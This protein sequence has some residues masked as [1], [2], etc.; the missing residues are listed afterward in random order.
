ALGVGRGF[1]GALRTFAGG[2]VKEYSQMYN[3][4]R[5]LALQRLEQEAQERGANA[6]VDI[7][8]HIIPFGPGVREMLMVGTASHNPVLGELARPVTSE[9][10]GEELWNLT[11]LGYAPVRLVLGTSVYALGFGAGIS[12]FFQSLG[13]GEINAVTRLV[14]E[15]RE[16]CL[17]H[18]RREA[19]DLEADGVIGTKV[20]IYEI[21]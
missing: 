5:H 4:T 19:K 8:T 9:L 11:Q 18:I 13:R 20:F 15:A 3:H 6:V 14:Y 21:S 2:E 16:N 12:T 7:V 1:L 17:D 10:T